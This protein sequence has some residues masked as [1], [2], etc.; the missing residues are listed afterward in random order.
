[1]NV[2]QIEAGHGDGEEITTIN[3]I[4]ENTISLIIINMTTNNA[5][6][7][8]VAAAIR[9]V[10][11]K[12]EDAATHTGET[13]ITM[14]DIITIM[15]LIIDTQINIT[16]MATIMKTEATT[17]IIRATTII[18]KAISTIIRTTTMKK[19]TREITNKIIIKTQHITTATNPTTYVKRE[20]AGVR[21][22]E[23][24][25]SKCASTAALD[26]QYTVS[27]CFHH[28]SIF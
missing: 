5:R 11:A 18:I 4:T 6:A 21:K 16:I 12:T 22:P 26:A 28:S 10:E 24:V 7:T 14:A 25:T 13:A 20:N 8:T 15:T 17:T 3:T 27:R 2:E 1:M 9:V 19:L 23:T